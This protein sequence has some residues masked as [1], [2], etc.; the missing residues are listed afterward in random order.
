[1]TQFCRDIRAYRIQHALTLK[2]MGKLAMVAHNTIGRLENGVIPNMEIILKIKR[3]IRKP[4]NFDLLE[5][6]KTNIVPEK[7]PKVIRPKPEPIPDP[8][9]A[10]SKIAKALLTYRKKRI[11]TRTE[12]ADILRVSVAT[13]ERIEYEA[14]DQPSDS[15]LDRVRKLVNVDY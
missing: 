8:E 13:I 1:M 3:V 4:P 11:L 12:V 7:P 2:D 6:P 15:I 14:T 9:V 5:P 10:K